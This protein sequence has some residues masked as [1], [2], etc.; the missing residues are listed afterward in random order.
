MILGMDINDNFGRG[1]RGGEALWHK[2][3][4][5]NF[6]CHK[7]VNFCNDFVWL[8]IADDLKSKIWKVYGNIFLLH[9]LIRV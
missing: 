5:S 7:I 2:V 6:H 8:T 9:P 4:I 3:D 1:G